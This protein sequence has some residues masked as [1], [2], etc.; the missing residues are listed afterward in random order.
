MTNPYTQEQMD[1][2]TTI[3]GS[4]DPIRLDIAE[5]DV[6]A[7]AASWAEQGEPCDEAQIEMAVEYV[8]AVRA[9]HDRC[10]CGCG[11]SEPATTT[12]DSGERV[13]DEC[14]SYLVDD[15]GEVVCSRRTASWTVCHVCGETIRWGRIQ[16][17]Q[18]GSPNYRTGECGCGEA[19][20]EEDR[21]GWGHYGYSVPEVKP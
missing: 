18:P 7:Q 1:A 4:D 19:W 17:G 5:A 10:H 8:S 20:M 16:T 11:C 12:D 15:G 2:Y 6:R 3:C 21:G 14:A 13:C 9:E